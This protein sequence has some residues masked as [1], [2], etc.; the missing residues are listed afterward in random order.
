VMA[1]QIERMAQRRRCTAGT[2]PVDPHACDRCATR[3]PRPSSRGAHWRLA[4]RIDE[5]PRVIRTR[6]HHA[7]DVG[8]RRLGSAAP[9]VAFTKYPI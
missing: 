5:I 1:E 4:G 6:E 8:V 7:F 9:K 3:V 2:K